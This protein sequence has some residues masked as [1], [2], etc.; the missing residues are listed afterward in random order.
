MHFRI[1]GH[2]TEE[3]RPI[4]NRGLIDGDMLFPF[5]KH[6]SAVI[7]L[8]LRFFRFFFLSLCYVLL[9]LTQSAF[10]FLVGRLWFCHGPHSADLTH[11]DFAS[12][13]SS[14]TTYYYV[15]LGTCAI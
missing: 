13:S 7:S 5:R 4:H 6:D 3:S 11:R 9:F 10:N 1:F 12:V 15:Q 8:E 2:A 14:L